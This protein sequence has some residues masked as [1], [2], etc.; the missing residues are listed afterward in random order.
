MTICEQLRA[1]A[2]GLAALPP[3]DPERRLAWE[4]ARSCEGC[5]RA[6]REAERLQAVLGAWSPEP[7]SSA[8]LSRAAAAIAVELSAER[9][10]RSIFSAAAAGAFAAALVALARHRGGSALDW[11]TASLLAALAM[12]LAALSGRRPWLVL[13]GVLGVA[14]A[15]ALVE[16][17]PGP[18][19]AGAGVECLLWE[20]VAATVVALAGWLALRG[21]TTAPPRSALAAAA[22]A[23]AL[24]G[25]AALQVTCEAHAVGPHLLAFHVGGVLLAAGI[26]SLVWRPRSRAAAA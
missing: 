24:A 8:T 26:A 7:I 23:G 19:E 22:A 6:L 16:G 11:T 21:G 17:R 15:G 2:P 12:V 10:R 14:L 1:E 18:L 3:D 5:A 9:R 25:D 13:G 20:L 4:H